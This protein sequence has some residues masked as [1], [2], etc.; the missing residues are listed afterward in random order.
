MLQSG[1]KFN[2]YKV[3]CE[4]MS[5]KIYK[6]GSNSYKAQMKKLDSL[7]KW[8]K[9]KRVF[10]I[11]EVYSKPLLIQDNRRKKS[12][13]IDFI[14]KALLFSLHENTNNGENNDFMSMTTIIKLIRVFEEEFYNICTREQYIKITGNLDVSNF[15]LRGFKVEAFGEVKRIVA[16]A[17]T[18]LKGQ[19]VISY[20]QGIVIVTNDGVCRFANSEEAQLITDDEFIQN[21]CILRNL[22][23]IRLREFA[24]SNYRRKVKKKYEKTVFGEPLLEN[25]PIAACNYLKSFERLI[26]YFIV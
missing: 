13:Y 12:I 25:N 23:K 5:W 9:E 17:L 7:C 8:H 4:H 15:L 20:E 2:N 16:R 11:D 14:R 6:S 3:L 10:V 21:V 22:V 19:N 26:I 18:S 24:K 1:M